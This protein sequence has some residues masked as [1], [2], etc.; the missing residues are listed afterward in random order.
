[1]RRVVALLAFG[2]GFAAAAFAAK[3]EEPPAHEAMPAR[4]YKSAPG[5]ALTKVSQAPPTDIVAGFLR[6]K[7][8]SAAAV[9]SLKKVS[10]KRS[11]QTGITHVRME[12]RVG[13]LRVEG[14][15][16]KA[17]IN[18]RGEL[19]HLIDGLARVSGRPA[20]ARITEAQALSAA[21]AAL[22]PE[23]AAPALLARQG[24]L[25]EFDR[26]SFFHVAPTVE[27]VAIP[28]KVGAMQTGFLV[29][30]WTE[31]TNLLHETLV[32]GSGAVLSTE[33]RTNTDSYNVFVEAPDKGAQTVVPGAGNG[34]AESPLGWL[35]GAQRS[36]DI[37]GNNTHTY[38]DTDAN[39]K[40]DPGGD[41]VVGGNF[42]TAA[43]LTVSPATA[44]NREVAVQ[45]LFYTTNVI[46]DALF[47]AGFDEAAGNFQ[48]TN[49]TG[50][51]HGKDPVDAEAQDGSGVDNANFA[52][53]PDGV[54]PRMQMFL[55][56]GKGTHEV[57]VGA[58]TFRAQGAQF[59][60]AL[61]PTG[62]TAD[63]VLVDD[64]TA[65]ATD[66]CQAITNDLSGAIALL[67][68]GTCPFVVKVKNAQLAG[69]IG[70]I[71]ANHL[72][73]SIFTMSGAD[74]SITIPSVFIGLTDGNS[75]KGLLP[76]SGTIRLAD[77]PPLQRDGDVDSDIVWHEYGHGLTWRMIGHMSG[78]MAGAIGEGMG[79]VLAVIANED[80]VVGEYSFDDPVGIR[81][82]PYTDYPRTYGDVAGTE[83]HFD[84]EVYGAIG[85]RLF[86]LYGAANKAELLADLVDGMNF[87]ETKPNFEQMRDGI[88]ASVGAGNPD[89]V[90]EVWTAF[91]EYGVGEGATST[92]KGGAIIVSESFE[93][94]AGV[95]P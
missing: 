73:D 51:G 64:G 2:I 15:Y 80:D 20:P 7:G 92:V 42:L 49:L 82:A 28:A 36:T 33:L 89:R 4:V 44:D 11:A 5:Q 39:N 60:P 34:T 13:G 95:C 45:N 37:S 55:W 40:P 30:T 74:N 19:I 70:A 12:Q 59:G 86:Q 91:A 52:T 29:T 85:W 31:K 17:A 83:V 53:P 72:G 41:P 75:L 43:D 67:D 57:V 26:G 58:S 78:P 3:K 32:S 23:Q 38:L 88:L 8:A 76:A 65:P 54:N 50:E 93:V 1:M 24:N 69:A 21:L 71:V 63:I 56:T 9:A 35:A 46:H 25:A 27:R 22:H 10:E 62:L 48:E 61:D 47:T 14:A 94:P 84:G 77:P 79:D 6:S 18:G 16:L 68:R 87:T 81:S 90:C 66:A